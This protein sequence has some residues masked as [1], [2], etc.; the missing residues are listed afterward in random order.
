[1]K[2]LFFVCAV[3]SLLMA[4][5]SMAWATSNLNLSKSNVNRMVSDTTVVTPA[6]AAAIGDELDKIGHGV[7]EASVRE[8]LRKLG[9]NQPNLI[10]RIVPAG[11]GGGKIPAVLILKNPADE[12]AAREIAVSDSGVVSPRPIVIPKGRVKN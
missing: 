4:V 5:G 3:T 7:T 9:I 8:V 10:V 2:R 12:A 1:M 11:P 6:Q